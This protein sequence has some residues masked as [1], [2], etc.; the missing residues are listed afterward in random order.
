[1]K[2]TRL[3]PVGVVVVPKPFMQLLLRRLSAFIS[4]QSDGFI[5]VGVDAAMNES[6]SPS[7]AHFSLNKVEIFFAS[8]RQS[9]V[10]SARHCGKLINQKNSSTQLAAGRDC[11]FRSPTQSHTKPRLR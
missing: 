1:M 9:H 6:F 7:R 11:G 3:P 4:Y 10:M 8:Y 5:G 2:S